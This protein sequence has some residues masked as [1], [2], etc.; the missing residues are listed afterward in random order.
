MHIVEEGDLMLRKDKDIS[1]QLD[2][3]W[4]VFRTVQQVLRQVSTIL[5]I[6]ICLLSV[7][8]CDANQLSSANFSLLNR[9][10]LTPITTIGELNIAA[11]C[12]PG[13]QLVGGGYEIK[14]PPM[15]SESY[16]NL[17]VEANYPSAMDKWTVTVFN[18][19]SD[20][21][22]PN[23]GALIRADAYCLTK[24]S[25]SVGIEVIKSQPVATAFDQE[26]TIIADCPSGSFVLGGGFKTDHTLPYAGLYN[27]WFL[28]SAPLLN[29]D[30]DAV[31]WRVQQHVISGSLSSPPTTVAYVLCAHKNLIADKPSSISLPSVD[32]FGYTS[33]EGQVSCDKDEFTAGGGY[34]FIG[35]P[36]IPHLIYSNVAVN[37]FSTWQENA[38]YGYQQGNKSDVKA[39]AT[40][41][42]LPH[43]DL[44]VKITNPIDGSE[45]S[46]A[47]E[48][49]LTEPITFTAVATDGS[50]SPASGVTFEWTDNENPFGSASA[51]FSATLTAADC[52]GFISHQIVVTATDSVGHS[53]S[54]AV[55]VL[56]GPGVC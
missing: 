26:T 10:T 44:A 43:V 42:K 23:H 2:G 5:L 37:K 16:D 51:S 3:W 9:A 25:L 52:E 19:D 41:I 34:E 4:P 53:A 50:G 1:T 8:A 39:W 6:L 24:K 12:F 21:N 54:D 28:T 20:D 30:L 33:Y 29:S 36:L 18:P 13:E 31:G 56:A 45:I 22:G 14:K 40:C 48:G 47:P 7:S 17:I 55:L 15:Q 38:I 46:P 27:A 11:Q 49:G 35:D 32:D